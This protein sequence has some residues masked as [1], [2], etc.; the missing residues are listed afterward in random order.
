M[1][2]AIFTDTFSPQINGVTNTLNRML[3]WFSENEV[4]CVVFA[5]HYGQGEIAS[6]TVIRFPSVKFVL[7]PDCRLAAP[8]I[9]R[10]QSSLNEFKPDII[11]NMTEFYMGQAGISAAK[12]MGILAVSNYCTHIPQYLSYYKAEW[13]KPA[14]WKYMTHFHNKH[15]LTLCP[16]QDTKSTLE[17]V[18]IHN[19]SLFSRGIDTERFNRSKRSQ[20]LRDKMGISDRLAALYVGRLSVEKDLDVLRDAWIAI[21]KIHG[22]KVIMVMAGDGP[23]A[24]QY[25][26]EM[27]QDTIHTGFQRG[28]ALS[29]LYASC[30]FFVFPSSTETFGNVILE[31]MASGLPVIGAAAGGVGEIITHN[32]DGLVFK[33]REHEPLI[34]AIDTLIKRPDMMH[35]LAKQGLETANSRTWNKE[36]ERLMCHF[37]KLYSYHSPIEL[38]NDKLA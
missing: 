30:D 7:Y 38:K 25:K 6:D 5:P 28:E 3:R 24:A 36:F 9:F 13:L 20:T 22:D 27:P 2:I 18:G 1:K 16:S 32:H 14:T 10:I 19:V 4:A 33:A 17:Q 35:R 11:L 21:K 34:D 31:A 26:K 12:R 29:E 37:E 23:L 15:A 8:N